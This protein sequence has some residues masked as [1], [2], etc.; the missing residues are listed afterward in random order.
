MRHILE[1]ARTGQVSVSMAVEE[2]GL[3]RNRLD[4]LLSDY[5]ATYGPGMHRNSVPV[6]TQASPLVFTIKHT[7]PHAKPG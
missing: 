7:V 1:S 6:V 3:S 5:L 4:K 2:L